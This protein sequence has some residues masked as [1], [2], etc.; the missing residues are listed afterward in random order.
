MDH[1]PVERG[2]FGGGREEGAV[3]VVL[4]GG[5][6]QGDVVDAVAGGQVETVFCWVVQDV[7]ACLPVVGVFCRL[8]TLVEDGNRGMVG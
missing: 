5:E 6:D 4:F 2:G 7:G 3:R 8:L 1:V